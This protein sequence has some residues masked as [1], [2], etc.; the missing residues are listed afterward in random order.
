MITGHFH[1]GSG[2]GNQLARYVFVRVK[3]ADLGTPFSMIGKDLFKGASFMNLDMGERVP[4]WSQ[5]FTERSI[6][7]EQGVDIRPYDERT[8]AI[9]PFTVVDGEFQDEKYFIRMLDEVREWLR[10][11]P[12]DLPD[13]LCIINFRG[14]EYVGVHDLFLTK[15]YWETAINMMN[16]KYPNIRYEVHTDD[17]ETARKFFHGLPIIKDIALNWRSI[18]YAKHLIVSNSSFAIL[19]AILNE[20]VI[21]VIAPKYWARRN[22]GVQSME[23]NVYSKFTHV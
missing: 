16:E 4:A 9:K 20:N 18:R 23:Q 1:Q 8:E 5:G 21:E 14:G 10:V 15:E 2:L 13:D 11:E 6:N 22:I 7:N 3:A 17:P 19:P 12:L